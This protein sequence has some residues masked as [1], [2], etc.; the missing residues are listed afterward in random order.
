MPKKDPQP[1]PP[2]EPPVQ[3]PDTKTPHFSIDDVSAIRTQERYAAWHERS[4]QRSL[5]A[6]DS[7]IYLEAAKFVLALVLAPP[8]RKTAEG[9]PESEPTPTSLGQDPDQTNKDVQ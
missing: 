1:V 3:E 7:D 9:T 8:K 2:K 4:M 6:G 5:A